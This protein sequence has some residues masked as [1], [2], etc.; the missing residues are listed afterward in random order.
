MPE[1]RV[2][3]PFASAVLLLTVGAVGVLARVQWCVYV[4]HTALCVVA[5]GW[6]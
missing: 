5:K 4:V 1:V 6:I 2:R 3:A